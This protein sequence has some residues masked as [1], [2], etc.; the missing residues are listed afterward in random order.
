MNTALP[1]KSHLLRD[2]LL[3]FITV[4]MI[5][6]ATN[7]I[8]YRQT[9]R[10]FT[11]VLKA[12]TE[13][14]TNM[15]QAFAMEAPY[16]VALMNP[17]HHPK[18]VELWNQ[19][20]KK[21]IKAYANITSISVIVADKNK[22]LIISEIHR[23][24]RDLKVSSMKPAAELEPQ[25]QRMF[26]ILNATA[27]IHF[28]SDKVFTGMHAL[29]PIVD[30]KGNTIAII[31]LTMSGTNL[32]AGVLEVK[33][34]LYMTTIVAFIFAL[35]FAI[36]VHDTQKKQYLTN[37]R[38]KS[39]LEISALYKQTVQDIIQSFS[40]SSQVLHQAAI[41]VNKKAHMVQQDTNNSSAMINQ[42]MQSIDNLNNANERLSEQLSR[43][44]DNAITC[45]DIA[46]DTAT[47]VNTAAQSFD[48][49]GETSDKT[50]K[51]IKLMLEVSNRIDL[52]AVNA[53]I[54]AA[55]AGDFG[56][57]FSVVA[58]E[59]KS[60]S[61]E[62]K[63]AAESISSLLKQSEEVVQESMDAVH[64][65]RGSV[66][67]TNYMSEELS[68]LAKLQQ[69]LQKTI[70]E[71]LKELTAQSGRLKLSLVSV[72]DHV[73][74]ATY[75]TMEMSTMSNRLRENTQTLELESSS[76][77]QFLNSDEKIVTPVM[78]SASEPFTREIIHIDSPEAV[79][80]SKR[81][82]APQATPPINN[83]IS[84]ELGSVLEAIPVNQHSTAA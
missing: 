9:E 39:T 56:R 36:V 6:V 8:I 12:R 10:S 67:E 46:K 72:T 43:L 38:K 32:E 21:F 30:N 27:Q 77:L 49:I 71:T 76:F 3:V 13:N 5:V 14:T 28:L 70:N 63:K 26:K 33:N 57:G 34:T 20:L 79:L 60:L 47:R 81:E 29:A 24:A 55:R 37:L 17:S 64:S 11:Q 4:L 25:L 19:L 53:A 69:S 22:P 74:E 68:N 52:L 75:K 40:A 80:E 1:N 35:V 50:A 83:I 44:L 7:A 58:G 65:I 84:A 61:Q 42:F 41:A 62:A 48:T 82:K 18:S 23:E 73:E 51:A 31:S 66:H 54:E 16:R 45:H 59:I 2:P 15:I 78:K